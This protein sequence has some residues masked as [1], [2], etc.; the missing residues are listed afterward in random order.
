MNLPELAIP[1]PPAELP[2]QIPDLVHPFVVHF[3]IAL[4]FLIILFELVNLFAKKRT[5][6]VLSFVYMVLLTLIL[7]A[8]LLTGSADAQAAKASL[9][10]EA[11]ALLGEH[12]QWAVYLFYAS[13]VLMLIKLLSVMVRKTPLRVFF[14]IVLFL[15]AAATLATGKRGGELVYHY[16]VNVGEKKVSTTA[17]APAV[18]QAA[19]AEKKESEAVA[20]AA[21]SEA[22]APA[23]EKTE[24]PATEEKAPAAAE[25]PA[26]QSDEA[27]GETPAAS[28]AEE[29]AKAPSEEAAQPS[30]APE[31]PNAPEAPAEHPAAQ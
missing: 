14:L 20:P 11:K 5:L 30:E 19:P 29:H 1:M 12:K 17:P 25:T 15:Y 18:E 6:G 24:T 4:P 8:A 23:E 10:A 7:Y 28:T 22:N 26:A 2:L 27:K 9:S 16:G 31:A 3:A 13:V 21:K